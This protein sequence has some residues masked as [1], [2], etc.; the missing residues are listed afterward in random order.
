ML[1]LFRMIHRARIAVLNSF[2]ARAG[3]YVLYWMQQAQRVSQN[4]ALEYAI[5]QANALKLPVVIG[6]G[7]MDGYP[8]ANLR[9]YAFMLQGLKA[10]KRAARQRGI[11]MVIRRSDPPTIAA[12]LAREAAI[13]VCD[14]GYLLHQ[15]RWR[16]EL[17]D[18]LPVRLVQVE[19]DVVVPVEQA[20]QKA[21]Y[22][23][24]TIRPKIGK[25]LKEHLTPLRE[26]APIRD[27]LSLN[28]Q[29]DV[30][31]NDIEDTLAM[32][33]LD[34]DVP[35]SRRFVGGADQAQRLLREFVKG[36]L[37]GYAT[38]R[39]EP[40]SGI[41]SHLSPYLHFGQIAPLEIA[42]ATMSADVPDLD[43]AAFL[44][45]LIIRRELSCN[46]VQF[47]P[48]YW[49]YDALP[50]W[51]RRSLESHANDRREAIYTRKQLESA[52]TADP[53]WNAAMREMIHTGYMHNYM[54]MY[55]GKCLIGWKRHPR[56]AYED[57]LYL[58]NRYFLDGRD[59][60]GYA[61]VGWCFGLHD[62]PWTNRPVFGQIRYMNAAGLNRKLDMEA[63]IRQVDQW[64][65]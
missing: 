63:Y 17:A 43:K 15:R 39:N 25:L 52:Q 45:Q 58:N 6:F 21:E 61:G 49:S 34:R 24:R 38:V 26:Q 44:E 59:A 12:D 14:R 64:C 53:Y 13:V 42:L 27:A 36:P 62:R 65:R 32:L 22:A 31:I 33:K 23:A 30:D 35:P 40:A 57:L 19:S 28:L 29:D 56:E 1:I 60:N 37:R 20:S 46:Y 4:H 10:T 8:D 41:C 50:A 47:T 18:A 5:E 7:L 51:A 9:H 11:R 3:N 54:R 55:W 48:Q 2:P 16:D